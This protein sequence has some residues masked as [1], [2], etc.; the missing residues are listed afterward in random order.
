MS[1]TKPISEAKSA[2]LRGSL[3][4]LQRAGE[5]ARELAAQQGTAVWVKRDGRFVE[6]QP[7]GPA[8]KKPTR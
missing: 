1:Q 5:K 3:A 8:Q 7:A 2:L 4:A 6:E